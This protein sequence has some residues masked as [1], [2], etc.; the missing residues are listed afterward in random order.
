[1][2]AEITVMFDREGKVDS[3]GCLTHDGKHFHFLGGHDPVQEV[4]V[5]EEAKNGYTFRTIDLEKTLEE[6][7]LLRKLEEAAEGEAY[8]KNA[9]F[10][11]RSSSCVICNQREIC[12]PLSEI[13]KMRPRLDKLR[14]AKDDEGV[15][16]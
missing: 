11:E 4:S 9:F 6:L 1:M 12:K 16:A 14:A 3:F 10:E 13:R 15:G 7:G 5:E 2:S 8:C